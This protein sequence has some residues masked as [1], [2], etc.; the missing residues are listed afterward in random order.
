MSIFDILPIVTP[1]RIFLALTVVY[2]V[3]FVASNYRRLQHWKKQGIP[4]I[5]PWTI[6]FRF[7]AFVWMR[8]TDIAEIHLK[9]VREYGTI[10]GLYEFNRHSLVVADVQAVKD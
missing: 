10:F 1:L 5:N 6:P 8:G 7:L 4:E 3:K 9:L 2:I